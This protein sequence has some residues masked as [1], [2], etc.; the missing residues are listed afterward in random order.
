[1]RRKA[2]VLLMV[3][4]CVIPTACLTGFK[5][6][7][8]PVEEAFVEPNLLGNWAC[9][10]EDEP[11]P[12]VLNIMDFDG[13]QYYIESADGKGDPSH[14]RALGHRIED[15]AFLSAREL[16]AKDEDWTFL[17]YALSDIDHLS[18][19]PVDTTAFEDVIDDAPS[20]KQRLA[21]QMKDPEIVVSLLSCTRVRPQG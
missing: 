16:G 19:R 9:S 17:E 20:V 7:L 21:E 14:F 12:S 15:V 11:T 10:S 18:L 5:H 4:T 6:P 3:A 8:G 13:K 2:R 1:M